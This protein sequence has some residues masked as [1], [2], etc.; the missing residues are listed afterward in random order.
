MFNVD[1]M[2]F[3]QNQKTVKPYNGFPIRQ[4]PYNVK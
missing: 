4:S 1:N 2:I 3:L